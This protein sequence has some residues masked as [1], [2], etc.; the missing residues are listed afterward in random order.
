MGDDDELRPLGERLQRRREAD[1]VRL[2]QRR[3]HL[4]QHAD[5]RRVRVQQR[6]EQ[7]QRRQRTLAAG[8]HVERS[9]LLP[10]RL[11]DDVDA[12]QAL[13][14]SVLRVSVGSS[15]HELGLAAAE[16]RL[17]VPLE[18]LVH[19]A[20]GGGEALFYDRLQLVDRLLQRRFRLA[21]VGELRA[22]ELVPFLALGVVR[23]RLL[24]HGPQIANV[25]AYLADAVLER[26]RVDRR[27]A[28]HGRRLVSATV[29]RHPCRRL[30]GG[31]SRVLLR[32]R[33]D[34][35][36]IFGWAEPLLLQPAPQRLQLL[37]S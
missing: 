33:R 37:R 12:G 14:L 3:V 21:Q 16:E 2:I 24:V 8:E 4:V 31:R 20:E 30:A 13:L 11:G 7:G 6:E 32:G 1:H 22:Q 28:S 35:L 10:R 9:H 5:R 18:R 19:L 36:A 23:P 17:E 34:H 15:Q 25:R 29:R 26:R 27:A